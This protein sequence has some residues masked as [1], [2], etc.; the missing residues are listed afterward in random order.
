MKIEGAPNSNEPAP[1]PFHPSDQ[2]DPRSH[3]F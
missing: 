3:L 2:R 1:L